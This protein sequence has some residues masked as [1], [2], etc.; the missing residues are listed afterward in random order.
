MMIIYQKSDVYDNDDVV[1]YRF[2]DLTGPIGA[3]ILLR[4]SMII[5]VLGLET[6]RLNIFFVVTIFSKT[7]I[8]LHPRLRIKCI[9]HGSFPAASLKFYINDEIANDKNI[10]TI[11]KNGFEYKS[12]IAGNN[13]LPLSYPVMFTGVLK[14]SRKELDIV[15]ERRHFRS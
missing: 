7:I 15:L 11:S 8:L 10:R 5:M 1:D 13:I 12:K 9:S 3:I 4:P 2:T 14:S 6:G